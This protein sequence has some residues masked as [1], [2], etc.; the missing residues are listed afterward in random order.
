MT[1]ADLQVYLLDL[2]NFLRGAASTKVAGE[3]EYAASKLSAFKDY[4]LKGFADFLEKAEAD[5]SGE[6]ALKAAPAKKAKADTATISRQCQVILDLYSRAI[7]PSVTVEQIELAALEL[8]KLDPPMTRLDELAKQIG[9]SQKFRKKSDAIK[10][11]RQKI[12]SRKGAFE[13]PS[14]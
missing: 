11:I 10:A 8:K 13:R 5:S 9:F 4:K 3:L 6:P 2:A 12:V 7:D 1:V 14:A